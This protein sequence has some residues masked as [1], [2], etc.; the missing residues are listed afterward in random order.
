MSN[1]AI[2]GS[3]TALLLLLAAG[4][5]HHVK[6]A[7]P[8]EPID[9]HI[10]SVY[11]RPEHPLPNDKWRAIMKVVNNSDIGA[12][13]IAYIFRLPDRNEEIGRGYIGKI[14]P[15]GT[16]TI[17]SEDVRMPKGEYRIEAEIVLPA[18]KSGAPMKMVSTVNVGD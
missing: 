17:S 3:V 2:Q 5:A 1:R 11:A 15:G 12:R 4:C 8:G 9:I 10:V 6:M 14:F 18:A 7:A 13:N 16:L